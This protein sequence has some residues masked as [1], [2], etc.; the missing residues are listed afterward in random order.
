MAR[1]KP[2][3]MANPRPESSGYLKWWWRY[4]PGR[5]RWFGLPHPFTALKAED[6]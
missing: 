5:V 3:V 6:D 1:I 4:G 2:D